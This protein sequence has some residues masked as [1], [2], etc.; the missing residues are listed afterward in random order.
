MKSTHCIVCGKDM[1]DQRTGKLK[2]AW[3]IGIK[4]L[5]KDHEWMKKQLG[6]FAFLLGDDIPNLNICWE[7]TLKNYGLDPQRAKEILEGERL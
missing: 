7:C 3:I 6:E 5:K 2:E 4:N 1:A